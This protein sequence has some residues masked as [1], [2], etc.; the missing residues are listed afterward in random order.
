MSRRAVT[1]RPTRDSGGKERD[2]PVVTEEPLEIRVAQERV[3]MTLRTPGDDRHLALGF[4]LAEGVISSIDDVS[5]LFHCGRPGEP[6]YQNVIEVTPGPGANLDVIDRARRDD[7]TTAACG[8]CGRDSIDDLLGRIE[9]VPLGP[10]LSPRLFIEAPETLRTTQQ[11]FELTGG[12]HG[13]AALTSTGEVVAS[14]EDIGRH[15]AVDKLVGR[16]LMARRM[17]GSA[18]GPVLLVVSS[19]AGFEIVQKAA[20]ARFPA[21]ACVGAASSL[22]I[23][24]ADAAGI[25]LVAFARRGRFNLYTHPE[26]FAHVPLAPVRD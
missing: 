11:A 7:L 17:P 4:L 16:L 22:A 9:P 23:D 6:A 13:A 14:A 10:A 20:M 21:I 2:D 12:L 19:R 5:G 8:L 18:E 1:V 26:R 3:T 25:T 24:T 15:N